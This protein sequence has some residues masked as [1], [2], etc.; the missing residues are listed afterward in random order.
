MNRE[1]IKLIASLLLFGSSGIFASQIHM[2]SNEIVFLRTGIGSLL[3]GAIFLLTKK[4]R[5]FG[6]N[7]KDSVLL[8][9]SGMGLGG[10]WIFLHEAYQQI[11][12]GI[13]TLLYYCAPAVVM[14]LSPI[15]FKEKLNWKKGAGFLAVLC[16]MFLING[17]AVQTGTSLWGLFCAVMSAVMYAAMLITNKKAESIKGME[18]ATFQLIFSFLT[19]AVYLLLKDGIH[20]AIPAGDW[21]PVL[22]LGLVNTG[23]GCYMYFSSIG[24]LKVQTV[25]VCGY[26]EP[27]SAVVLSAVVLGEAMGILQIMGAVLILGGAMFAEIAGKSM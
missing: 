24:Y 21:L 5:A 3:L 9:L 20:I 23:F 27:L 16:G 17:Q 8:I 1:L 2:A 13:S 12:V 11:G 19:V 7:K 14:A 26:L 10:G 22:M 4:S 25:A 6:K 15:F 18:N